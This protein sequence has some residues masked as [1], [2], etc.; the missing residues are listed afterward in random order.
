[1]KLYIIQNLNSQWKNNSSKNII[2]KLAHKF[3]LEIPQ[4]KE[5][6]KPILNTGYI[7]ISHSN[8]FLVV[9]YSN[10]P[11]G[12]DCEIIRP[13]QQSLIDKLKLD[14][15]NPILD[16]C[17]RESVIKLLDDKSYLLKKELNEYYFETVSFNPLLCIV[18]A[19]NQPIP[20][21][22]IIHLDSELNFIDLT[23]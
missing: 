15:L 9:I 20:T 6:G 22:E 19:S 5:T 17:K 7:S 16:W 2:I 23:Q 8:Q 14:K 18:L 21:I 12:I 1:M 3:N 10:Q 4:Y 11:I 13:I